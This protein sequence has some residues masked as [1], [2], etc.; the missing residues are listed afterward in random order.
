MAGN[1]SRRQFLKQASVGALSVAAL[2]TPV[3]ARRVTQVDSCTTITE[4]G[5]Y[6]FASDI[7]HTTSGN[8]IRIRASN[9]T[10]DGKGFS[11]RAASNENT[12]GIS[13]DTTSRNVTVSNLTVRDFENGF[14]LVGPRTRVENVVVSDNRIQGFIINPSAIQ[15]T[16]TDSEI[17]GNGS[18]G[19][20]VFDA[21]KL[22]IS[23]N[24]ICSNNGVGIVFRQRV[25]RSTVQRND[26]S[27]NRVYGITAWEGGDRNR[28]LDNVTER[29]GV[30]GISINEFNP[31]PATKVLIK[32]NTAIGNGEDGVFL[33]RVDNSTVSD[34]VVRRN[35]DDGIELET[36]SNNRL[37]RNVVCDNGDEAIAI[38]PNSSNNR[39]RANTTVC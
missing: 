8:C 9:V 23:D 24:S 35:G 5:R 19:I 30:H 36:S 11:L 28:I 17:T 4:S 27:D 6:E 15:A 2:S 26:V 39:L 37:I 14:N 1:T 25:S 3:R 13:I 38:G 33:R 34:N 10:L 29:N 7:T 16:I 22:T 18:A 21:G 20:G 12:I 31:E 32:G